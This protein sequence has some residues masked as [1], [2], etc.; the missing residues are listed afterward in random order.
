MEGR[1][2]GAV[3]L[4]DVVARLLTIDDEIGYQGLLIHCESD[5][6]RKFYLHLVPGFEQSPTDPLH[7]ILLLKDTAHVGKVFLAT[8]ELI[9]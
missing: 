2:V 7:L 5:E 4:A 1:G 8:A 6:A 3:L 9:G